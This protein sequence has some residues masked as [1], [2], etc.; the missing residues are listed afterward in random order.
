MIRI[1]EENDLL[2]VIRTNGVR[3]AHKL[4]SREAFLE[5]S[6]LWLKT[7]WYAKYSYSFTWLGR[8]IIQLPE[9]MVR[10]Q[11][12]IYHLRPQAI[13][14]TGV[15]HGGSLIFYA[16]LMKLLG[17]HGRVIGIDI[18]I[19]PHNRAAIESHEL[20]PY[21]SLIEGSSI[22]PSVVDR[23]RDLVKTYDRVLV[24]LDSNHDKDHVLA[25]LRAYTP[26]VS[27]GSYA[28]ATDGIKELV[29]GGPRTG[30][31]WSWNHPRAAAEQFVVENPDFSIEEPRFA[32][33]EGLVDGWIS[34]WTGGF[35]KRL[36]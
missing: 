21:I 12:V 25:E 1:D 6:R 32:F 9:D 2:E 23:V 30:P 10:I 36:R 19:R 17:G 14:E 5:L 15:A 35:V 33:N 22:E 16:S 28:I 11:E 20:S 8:P 27:V 18:E 26:L 29:A 4:S 13:I 34:Q 31:D 7:G 3:S 24:I